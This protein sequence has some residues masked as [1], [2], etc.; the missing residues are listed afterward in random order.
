MLLYP[1]HSFLFIL[2]RY[3]SLMEQVLAFELENNRLQKELMLI[4]ERNNEHMLLKRTAEEAGKNLPCSDNLT[5]YLFMHTL[6]LNIILF[7]T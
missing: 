3:D 1:S 4:Q 6:W 7:I 5:D 2:A